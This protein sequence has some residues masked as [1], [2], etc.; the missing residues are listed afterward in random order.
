MSVPGSASPLFLATAAAADVAAYQIDR[1]LRFNSADSAYLSKDFSTAGNRRTWTWSGW[2][3]RGATDGY[4]ALFGNENYDVIQFR[5]GS[6][7][8]DDID[9]F[10]NGT[11]DGRRIS[12]SFFRDFSAWYHIVVACDTTQAA[13]SDKVKLYVNGVE[14]S[15]TAANAIANNYQTSF[16][17]NV[18]HYVGA[19]KNTSI[20][21]HFDGYLAEVYFIDGQALA[22][23][24]FGEYDSNSVWQPKQYSGTYGTNGFYL[25][26]ADNSS[27]SA[28]GTDSSGNSNTWTVNNLTAEDSRTLNGIVLDGS[29]DY[30]SFAN[31]SDFDLGQSSEAFTIEAWVKADN[32]SQ[33]GAIFTRGGGA[34]GWN[35]TDGHNYLLM[36]YLGSIYFQWWEGTT[37]RS[38][39]GSTLDQG[40]WTHVAAV[41]DG[42]DVK[43]YKNGTQIASYSNAS[44]GLV[45]TRDITSI[46]RHPDDTGDWDG[47][48]SNV[49]VVKGTAVY[50]QAFTPSNDLTNVTNT[51]VLCC[52]SS[53]SATASVVTP[54]TITSNGNVAA[55]TFHDGTS[56]NDSL[57]DTP[58]NYTASGNNGGNYATINALQSS[59]TLSNG[60]LD[61]V[62][63]TNGNGLSVGTIGMSSGKYYWEVTI[64]AS[65]SYPVIGIVGNGQDV[66][67]GQYVGYLSN[68]WGYQADGN[69]R[70]NNSTSSYGSTYAN[71]DV[72]GVA[73][74]ADTGSLYFYKNGTAQNSGTAVTTSADSGPYFPAASDYNT[75]TSDSFVF[76][77]G[78][79]PFAYTP[80]TGYV[81]LCTQ[82]L[83][84]SACASIPDGSTEMDVVL[85]TGNSS[86]QDVT[87]L[88]FNPD[89]LWVKSRT[90]PSSGN[91]H[92][93]HDSVR[94][95]SSGFYKNLYSNTDETEDT[96]SGSARGGVTSFN[97]DGFSLANSGTDPDYY[98]LN[99]NT[100]TYVAWAWNAGTTAAASNTDGNITSSVKV[101]QSAGFSIV[102]YSASTQASASVG[103]G[104]NAVPTFIIAKSRTVQS[105]WY[106][107]FPV[108][109]NAGKINQTLYLNTTDDKTN[110]TEAWGHSSQMTTSTFAVHPTSGNATNNGD[111]V[112]YVFTP[113]EGFSAF[114][115]YVGTGTEDNSA[116]FVYCGFRPKFLLLKNSDVGS[117]GYDWHINDAER[118]SYNASDSYLNA[119]NNNQEATYAAIDFLSNGFKLKKTGAS[120]NGDGHTHVFA[121]F[122]EHPFRTARAR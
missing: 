97:N 119:N 35:S 55:G 31:D 23:S 91:Y 84:E 101:N 96:Y 6:G 81:S 112:A 14:Q 103:H 20:F 88:S 47:N 61:V 34:S 89:L 98:H 94:G 48:I 49:R 25:K 7:V 78:Q 17:S 2:V 16:N 106:V 114:G 118:D 121:A 74:D 69:S 13:A 93:L 12:A 107:W 30:L 95:L 11:T 111:M 83:S 26:F 66:A 92:H 46:G 42:T 113:I 41:Y 57:I 63:P 77:F 115:S 38:I 36:T 28:L 72:I 122:A 27:N 24:D 75:T 70:N 60:N 86:T 52:K 99:Q 44:F 73:F 51:I 39:N 82:N 90:N 50:T 58:T 53:S 71:G 120:Y 104:L 21:R 102:T 108:L 54:S 1:S 87:G 5:S 116:P 19:T 109:D 100:Y 59:A 9:I 76:N 29:D 67:A 4:V 68:S 37:D 117:S 8:N 40:K 62:T 10:F 56:A 64:N 15:L 22:A 43:L 110:V 45:T 18:E 65:V 32:A 3:K 85:Y 80:P 105:N 33:T 79:R